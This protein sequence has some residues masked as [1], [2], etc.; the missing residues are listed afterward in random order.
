MRRPF[1]YSDEN[2]TGIGNV[3][4][5]HINIKKAIVP[6]D[7]IL[8]IPPEIFNRMLFYTQT[9]SEVQH[10][11]NTMA[12]RSVEVGVKKLEGEKYALFSTSPI[13]ETGTYLL[14]YYIL[15]DV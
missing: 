2:F 15:I 5:C 14:G 8:E 3:L 9:F 12:F 11:L 13:Y 1:S 10:V 4:F 6:P 7:T